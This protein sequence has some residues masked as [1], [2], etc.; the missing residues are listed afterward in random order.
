MGICQLVRLQ[1]SRLSLCRV[2][3]VLVV[4][5]SLCRLWAENRAGLFQAQ[6]LRFQQYDNVSQTAVNFS[7]R[8]VCFMHVGKTGG[9]TF[10]ETVAGNKETHK[11][12]LL[13]DVKLWREFHVGKHDQLTYDWLEKCDLF[14]AWVRDPVNRGV[15]AFTFAN[16]SRF[17]LGVG[18]FSFTLPVPY[19]PGQVN[20]IA[21]ALYWDPR[22]WVQFMTTQH[23]TTGIAWYLGPLMNSRFEKKL[24]FVG[25]QECY[26]DD[27]A[28]FARLANMTMPRIKSIHHERRS[29]EPPFLSPKGHEFAVVLPD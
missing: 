18:P 13:P 16:N 8:A 4:F 3:A 17:R 28:R 15:S 6:L 10:R 7:D 26:M 20:A 9:A 1:C 14:V 2:I 5:A 11:P 21:E 29:N 19:Q 25:A 23:V 12:L 22:A 27:F 24:I